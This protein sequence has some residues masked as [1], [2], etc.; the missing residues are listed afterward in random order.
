[1]KNTLP[2]ETKIEVI[3]INGKQVFKKIMNYADALQMEKKKG[4]IYKF[5]QLGFS[6]FKDAIDLDNI[7]K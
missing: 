5:Y 7:K 1:M 3:A 4:W 6:Q 2:E